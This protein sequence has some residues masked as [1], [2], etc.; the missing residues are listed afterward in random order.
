MAMIVDEKKLHDIMERPE[1]VPDA[2]TLSRAGKVF[3]VGGD[4][5]VYETLETMFASYC[6]E[7]TDLFHLSFGAR[8]D[9]SRGEE[10][11]RQIKKNF[12]VRLMGRVPY[13]PPA[14]FIE[15]AYAAGVDMLDIAVA[16]PAPTGALSGDQQDFLESLAVSVQLFPRWSAASTLEAGAEPPAVIAREIDLLLEAGVVPLVTLSPLVSSQQTEEIASVFA[17]L[18]LG[19]ERHRAAV[20]PF[21]PLISLTTP[22]VAAENAGRLRNFIDRIRDRQ[23]LAASGLRRHLRVV[24]AEDSLDSAGL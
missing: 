20:K 22:L 14:S 12:N 3:F 8:D 18:A 1:P 7:S 15:R 23:L 24:P 16:A 9:F 21:L 2:N 5:P 10:M 19:W 13:V 6:L 4:L 11:A 17:H